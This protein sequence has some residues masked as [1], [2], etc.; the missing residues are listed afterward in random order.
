MGMNA[1]RK[2]HQAV[3]TG[4]GSSPPGARVFRLLAIPL[5]VY[6]AWFLETFLFEGNVHLFQRPDP[7]GVYVY[8]LLACIIIGTVAPVFFIRKA[9]IAGEITMFQLGFRSIRRTI[10]VCVVTCIIGYATVLLLNLFGSDLFLFVNAFLLMVPTAIASVMICWVLAG[11]HLQAL[12]RAG[13]ALVSISTGVV[14]TSI[15]FGITAL[16]HTPAVQQRDAVFFGV[17][18]GIVVA[19]FFFAVR[20]VYATSLVAAGCS[21][22]VMNDRIDPVSLHTLAPAVWISAALAAVVLM[23]IHWYL[24]RNYVTI[25]VPVT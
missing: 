3:E 5:A 7:A 13:G 25:M 20:D 23:G 10:L 19:L 12:V 6:A 14:V 15:L 8:T 22:F 11:T 9:F 2:P 21:V 18:T 1:Q 4:H 24:A 17:C 16:A